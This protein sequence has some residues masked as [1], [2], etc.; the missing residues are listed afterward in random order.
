MP[1]VLISDSMDPKAAEIFRAKGVEVDERPGLSKEE[2]KAII[3]GYDGLAIRSATKVT[4]DLLAAA[5]NLKVIGRAG[6][7][8]DNV[9]IPAA[10]AR[11]IVVMNTPFGNSITTA[12]HAIA[13]MFALARDLPA[14][15]SSTQ[16]G[17]WEKNRFMGVELTNKTLGLIGAGNIGSIVADRALGLRM[18]VVAYDPFL[19]PER[20]LDLGVEKVELD[21]LLARADFIT[22]HT[23]LTEQTRNILSRENLAKTRKGVRI[24]NCARG[25]LIDEAALKEALETGHVA[26][27][28][29]DVFVEEPA[30]ASP[31]FGTPGLVATPHLGASTT[32]AQVN[33]AIQVAE[34]M[35]EFLMRGGVT[36]ALNM[37]SLSAEEAPRLRPYMALAEK[38]GSLV[39]QLSHGSIAGLSIEAE[40]A[41]AELNMKPIT[42][43]VLAGFMRIHSDTV[44][45]VNA[46]F[47]AKERGLDVREIRHDRETDYHTLLRVSAMTSAGDRPVVGTLFANSAPRLVEI[48]G[49]RVEAELEGEMIYIVNEDTPGFIGRLGTLLGEEGVNIG[50]FSLGRREAGGE[51]VALVSVD[52]HIGPELVQRLQALPGVK[53]VKPLRF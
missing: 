36:N 31:L 25:G 6:I 14:A 13:L 4:D 35:A 53:T 41:A 28:A 39:G 24:V 3:G 10:T 46:P 30:K 42:G 23:P 52:S 40:G 38:L 19:T 45:M 5:T 26:G 51:A 33:V 11:G 21:D 34:Q 47:L 2:L 12:E 44:N 18:K 50:T 1:K 15:D 49:I 32:E 43:A 20:A 29:L 27:A 9:D 17:K 7:G 22:L 16:A 37:P 8:V 48:F